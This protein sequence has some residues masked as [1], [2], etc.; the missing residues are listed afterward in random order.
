MMLIFSTLIILKVKNCVHI[1]KCDERTQNNP[2][3]CIPWSLKL[4]PPF[5]SRF[6]GNYISIFINLCHLILVSL[7]FSR[8]VLCLH[9]ADVFI[10]CRLY[11]AGAQLSS[12]Y[13]WYTRNA[14]MG[15]KLIH[16]YFSRIQGKK[17]MQSSCSLTVKTLNS[18]R[19][20]LFVSLNIIVW[21]T[22]WSKTQI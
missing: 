19:T 14:T 17:I 10:V 3:I 18:P 12:S 15:K 16:G 7:G 5:C 20:D 13:S 1:T 4:Q 6:A 21:K 9:Y 2:R 22:K 11:C 8:Y